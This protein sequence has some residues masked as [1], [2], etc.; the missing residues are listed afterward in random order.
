MKS[1]SILANLIFGVLMG[2][3]CCNVADS[4]ST[5]NTRELGK[6]LAI[7]FRDYLKDSIVSPES[8]ISKSQFV[9]PAKEMNPH[10]EQ[11][12]N[13]RREIIKIGADCPQN[14]LCVDLGGTSLKMAICMVDKSTGEI[15]NLSKEIKQYRIPKT[16]EE[17]NNRTIYQFI[18]EKVYDFLASEESI[19]TDMG[20]PINGALTFSYPLENTGDRV[21]VSKFTK[22]FNWKRISGEE[23]PLDELNKLTS[24]KVNFSVITNDT[25]SLSAW[26]YYKFKD[27]IGGFVLGTG[28]NCS[29]V[30]EI[31][32]ESAKKYPA[33]SKRILNTECGSIFKFRQIHKYMDSADREIESSLNKEEYSQFS[34]E[35]IIGGL[36]FEQYINIC[37]RNEIKS[38]F[39]KDI[40]AAQDQTKHILTNSRMSSNEVKEDLTKLFD[41]YIVQNTLE[42]ISTKQLKKK[43]DLLAKE[44]DT[45]IKLATERKYAICAGILAGVILKSYREETKNRDLYLFAL[46]GSGCASREFENRVC[47]EIKSI[48]HDIEGSKFKD[49]KIVFE[50]SSEA[51]V[52]GG[53]SAYFSQT[54][55]SP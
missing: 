11:G 38:L 44:M 19:V 9:M 43:I 33:N 55:S 8:S 31:D 46:T 40:L 53:A 14:I 24:T 16:L 42:G 18:Q 25:T 28:V 54:L 7:E 32:E 35:Q 50:S 2:N 48:L 29:Y 10:G 52:L 1:R 34:L 12:E 21:K 45:T 51:S 13:P 20:G 22:E 30:E 23:I 3:V 49:I 47:A 4:K 15:R 41:R 5:F 36:Y 17:I 39:K 6:D 27:T 37:L 26:A